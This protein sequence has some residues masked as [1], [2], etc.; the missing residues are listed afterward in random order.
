[1]AAQRHIQL[2]ETNAALDPRRYAM[3]VCHVSSD[4]VGTNPEQIELTIIIDGGDVGEPV[5]TAFERRRTEW[6]DT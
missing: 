1:M 6:L 5:A 4:G 3:M 2:C